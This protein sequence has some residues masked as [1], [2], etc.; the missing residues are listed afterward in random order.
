V[1]V[2]LSHQ[3]ADRGGRCVEMGDAVLVDHVPEPAH[4]RDTKAERQEGG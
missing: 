4:C 2:P 3:G 1:L